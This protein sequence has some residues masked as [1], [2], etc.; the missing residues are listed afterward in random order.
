MSSLWKHFF[1]IKHNKVEAQVGRRRATEDVRGNITRGAALIS[2]L[3]Q[4]R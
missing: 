4:R 1:D 3:G 2:L